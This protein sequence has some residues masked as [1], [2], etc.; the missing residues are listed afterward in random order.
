MYIIRPTLWLHIQKTFSYLP[1][2][3]SQQGRPSPLR[4][5]CISPPVSDSPYFRD[6]FGLWRKCLQFYFSRQISWFSS[7]EISGDLFFSHWPQISNF[8][9][10]FPCFN[11]FPP[12]SRKLFSPYFDKFPPCFRQIHMLFTCFTCISFP[13]MRHLCITQCT[14]W[15]PLQ[16]KIVY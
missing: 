1:F 16:V 9:S 8:P 6:I 12:V 10:Y 4:P 2:K 5:W 7:T 11:T 15:T 14:Y 13:P 3:S